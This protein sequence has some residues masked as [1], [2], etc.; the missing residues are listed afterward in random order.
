LEVSLLALGNW[1][2]PGTF[3]PA[4]IYAVTATNASNNTSEFAC[5][6][7]ISSATISNNGPLCEGSTLVL[8][9]TGGDSYLWSG[10]NG[11]NSSLQNPSVPNIPAAG[12]G[13]YSV[14]ITSGSC[15]ATLTTEVD[16]IPAADAGNGGA[17]QV[18]NSGGTII[19]LVGALGGTPD[20][21]GT[22]SDDNGSG[23]NLSNPANVNFAGI[24][25][26]VYV[27]TYTVVG[28]PPCPSA[29]ASVTV[30]VNASPDAGMNNSA[31]FCTDAIVDLP[32][33]LLGMPQPGGTWSDD[34]GAG[35]NLSNPNSVDFT[36][37]PEGDYDFT[38]TVSG[39]GSCPD[40]SATVTVTIAGAPDAGTNGTASICNGGSTVL[41]L[42][43]QL[44]GTPDGGGSWTDDSGSGVNLSN[45]NSVDFSGVAAGSYVFTYTIM[46]TSPSCSDASATVTVT[47]A[48]APDAG[49]NGS[50]SI[51]NTSTADLFG[52]LGGTPTAGGTWSDDNG[53]GVN[54]SNPGLVDFNG[55]AGGIYTFTYSVSGVPPCT[56]ANAT[57]TVTVTAAANAGMDGTASVCNA[58]VTTVDLP[59]SLTGMPDMGG[60]WSD[61]SGAGVNLGTPS[62]VDFSGVA[63]GT[64]TFTYTIPAAGDCPQSTATVVVTVNAAPDAGIAGSA[65]VCDGGTLNFSTALG[66]TPQPGGTWSDDDGSGV[67]LSNPSN[68]TFA[69]V[70]TGTYN[71]TYTVTGTAPCTSASAVLTVMVES[72][73]NA[74]T[75]GTA[76]VCN[77]GF[78]TL[79]DLFGSLGGTPDAG[80]TWS[81]DSG[82]GVNLADPSN[83]DFIGVFAGTYTFTYA[84]TGAGNCPPASATVTVTV[85]EEANAGQSNSIE[86]CQGD[87]VDFFAALSGTPD[88]GGTWSDDSGS[89]VNLSNPNAV[90]F[91]G[92]FPGVYNYT[93]SVS[94]VPPC[95][96]SSA[97]LTVTVSSLPDAGTDGFVSACFSPSFLPIDLLA[98]LGGTPDFGG[99]WND[100]NF[101]G[102]NLSNPQNVDFVGIFPG[103]YTFTYTVSST[104]SCPVA[105][106]VVSVT[107]DPAP[108]AGTDGALEI[109]ESTAP[110]NTNLFA[111]LGGTPDF[112]GTW[113]DDSGTGVN[114]SDP[115][116]VNFAGVA[117]GNYQFTYTVFGGAG[118][119]N[120][121]AMV[122][123]IITALPNA[124]TD[125]SI[126]LCDD[127]NNASVNL[128]GALGGSPD[129]GGSWS[130]NDFSGVSL[131]DPFNVNF[132]G[133]P[134]GFYQFT[135]QVNS[136]TPAC[137]DATAVVTVIIDDSPNAGTGGS[138]TVC[139]FG[140]PGETQVDLVALLSD[141]PDAG[142]TWSDDNGVGVSLA[143]PN[144][145][146]FTGV[147][148]GTYTFTYTVVGGN[149]AC[150]QDQT[151]VSILVEDCSCPGVS[152][153]APPP[154]CNDF[155]ELDLTTLEVNTDPGTWS[156]TSTPPGSSPAEL[157]GSIFV[158]AFADPGVYTITF[159]LD[160]IPADPDCPSSASQTI[161]VFPFTFAGIGSS[162]KV[163]NTDS[164]V[165]N[166]FDQLTLGG[167]GGSWSVNPGSD[168]P[169]AGTFDMAAGTFDTENH[170]IGS[171]LF[172]YTTPSNA[173]CPSS[174]AMVEVLI[175]TLEVAL[176]VTDTILCAGDSTGTITVIATSG[177]TSL[178]Y[179]WADTPDDTPTRTDLA[180][181]T[182]EVTVIDELGCEAVA[183]IMLTAPD[184][185]QLICG[186]VSPTTGPITSDGTANI[187]ISGGTPPYAIA[188]DGP[189]MGDTTVTSPG[190]TLL[191]N[192]L[193][194]DYS[195]TITDDN[196]C[197]AICSFMMES[198][199]CVAGDSTFVSQTTC[200]PSEVDTL[201]ATFQNEIGCDSVVVFTIDLLPSQDIAL[202]LITC[203]EDMA[204]TVRDTF[205]NQFGCDSI[206]KQTFIYSPPDTTELS[207][208]SCQPDDAGVFTEMLTNQAGCDSIVITTI[209]FD[210]TDVDTTNL[211]FLTCDEAMAGVVQDTFLN[212]FGCDSIVI[213]TTTFSPPDTTELSEV[214]CQPDDAGVFT[215]VL[216][217]QLGCDSVIITTVTFDATD[218]DTTNLA[219][220]TCDEAMAGIVQDTFLN[221]FGCD[222]IVIQTT[223]FS[224]PDTTELSEVS[225]QPDD[226]GVF[227]EVLTNQLGCDSVIITTVTFDATD[228]DTTTL[229]FLTCD[230]AMAGIVQDTFL[231]QFGCDSIVIQTTTF[232]PPDTTELSEVSCQPD[233]AGVFT[234]VLTN[235]LGCD[236]VI[237]TTVTFDATDV[238]TTTLNFL[239]CDEAMAGILQDTLTNQ[240]G[241]DSIII[242]NYTTVRRTRRS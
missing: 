222:S 26:G 150:P 5:D 74:G 42:F 227:T 58:G 195:V 4:L 217:N 229:N 106:A 117:P 156:I 41:D 72:S 98:A 119:P 132:S 93:Y 237:I 141:N 96:S 70:M 50:L 35:V 54:L 129:F 44:G 111:G 1:T 27:F 22:W 172:D 208:V 123:V 78:S 169:E 113:S 126:D 49:Q 61:D 216:T 75:N 226:A 38:Y 91:S 137:P 147:A 116:S 193:V 18:C 143:N 105:S 240:F 97:V 165:I 65:T 7:G 79:V 8:S 86:V 205:I 181:G 183:S 225:C 158:A 130:D 101:T 121:T 170:P 39:T 24:A 201:I 144:M 31:T 3:D 11:F 34:S 202:E 192:L 146:D 30:T 100:D 185:L 235:Q 51:C 32:G 88:F 131:A 89:G 112:T 163:C 212:Q 87:V 138:I 127:N 124:G 48:A 59:G 236:S 55:V 45:P 52:A 198:L 218:V 142:G 206:V 19:N 182:Y 151:A 178:S 189:V 81:D 118:C 29:M 53:A 135:Y 17:V 37:V 238:D 184:T 241:C 167:T 230:E 122:F 200:D 40:G 77:G 152:I 139:N 221:Q 209:T 47:V 204:G 203:D 177:Q 228:V 188:W 115:F 103:T 92:V 64:Y 10:P 15:S 43:G 128:F 148:A 187:N 174:V 160:E 82:S 207:E 62:A 234:E 60:T 173:A 95:S 102:V 6:V 36:G 149:P 133:V 140:T 168:V 110:T 33:I 56:S 197:E 210:E 76:L 155:G 175:S 199:P 71:Y 2:F 46:A 196:G 171:Y 25:P 219:F 16:V 214:S 213:Q 239:T 224:P 20:P 215:E 85:N 12:D 211:A 136:T 66:G 83:V 107:I 28:T 186:Q 108:D 69:G 114:L 21:G 179:T 99:T 57:V 191:Q 242:Q 180:A 190:D 159:T 125:G 223:T 73:P 164:Q 90:N 120:A 194:G 166:L 153:I 68:V 94:S 63:A 67:N 233:D 162:I 13:T 14:T 157:F 161:E 231:N 220:L 176:E 154:L 232:S 23:V 9:A 104:P 109:C 145:V 80:G 84:V 134:V